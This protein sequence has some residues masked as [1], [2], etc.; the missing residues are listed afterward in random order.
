M[1]LRKHGVPLYE[2]NVGD[3]EEMFGW[4]SACLSTLWYK[5]GSCGCRFTCALDFREHNQELWMSLSRFAAEPAAVELPTPMSRSCDHRWGCR[6]M[7]D[8]GSSCHACL[9]IFYE[10]HLSRPLTRLF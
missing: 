3:K 1:I 7:S 2:T 9:P 5:C 10:I 6:I 8:S 4:S